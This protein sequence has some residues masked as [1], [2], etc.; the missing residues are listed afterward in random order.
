MVAEQRNKPNV[1]ASLSS[2][3]SLAGGG[4]G[5]LN[6]ATEEPPGRQG[7]QQVQRHRGEL[8]SRWGWAGVAV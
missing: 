8:K 7:D 3:L 6:W 2:R 1:Q 4:G 5:Q